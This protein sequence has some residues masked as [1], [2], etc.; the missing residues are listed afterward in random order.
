MNRRHRD[1]QSLALPTE[2][3]GHSL[4]LRFVRLLHQC[5]TSAFLE[6]QPNAQSVEFPSLI[7]IMSATGTGIFNPLLY[8]LSYPGITSTFGRKA[9]SYM[10]ISFFCPAKIYAFC[11]SCC[12]GLNPKPSRLSAVPCAGIPE[13]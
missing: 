3:S 4:G 7:P 5:C 12:W 8:R 13:S 10:R 2:L 11:T 1:F 6:I 9:R